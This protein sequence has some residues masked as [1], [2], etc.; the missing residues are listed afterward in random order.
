MVEIDAFGIAQETGKFTSRDFL[1]Q[2]YKV[3]AKFTKVT[4]VFA[5]RSNDVVLSGENSKQ[6]SILEQC[7]LDLDSGF[8]CQD[9]LMEFT[10]ESKLLLIDTEDR[11]FSL[12][13]DGRSGSIY[14]LGP[15]P[16]TS[17]S[18][19][20]YVSYFTFGHDFKELLKKNDISDFEFSRTGIVIRMSDKDT[21]EHTLD[22]VTY[23]I[24][25]GLEDINRGL[26]KFKTR[27]GL[28]VSIRDNDLFHFNETNAAHT[29]NMGAFLQFDLSSD[30]PQED[31]NLTLTA[32]DGEIDNSVPVE[33]KVYEALV[34]VKPQIP[35]MPDL[36]VHPNELLTIKFDNQLLE[37]NNL[38]F[39]I[40]S[41]MKNRPK[42]DSILDYTLNLVQPPD[43]DIKAYSFSKGYV[44]TW[45]SYQNDDDIEVNQVTAYI[46]SPIHQL[47]NQICAN[48][49]TVDIFKGEELLNLDLSYN[50]TR[51][52]FLVRKADGFSYKIKWLNTSKTSKNVTVIKFVDLPIMVKNCE[53]FVT[54]NTLYSNSLLLCRQAS[55]IRVFNL[56][57]NANAS[58]ASEF[59]PIT[60]KTLNLTNFC[61][62]SLKN[63]QLDPKLIEVLSDCRG[64]EAR[65]IQI[66][67]TDDDHYNSYF[68]LQ[69][70]FALSPKS[71]GEKGY[72][73]CPFKDEF[74]ILDLDSQ[75]I[76]SY[77]RQLSSVKEYRSDSIG[78][79][80]LLGADCNNEHSVMTI[81]GY[82]LQEGNHVDLV[83]MRANNRA[84]DHE[85]R[86]LIYTTQTIYEDMNCPPTVYSLGGALG[87]TY[88]FASDDT[89]VNRLIFSDSY[90]LM[91]NS[92]GQNSTT[93]PFVYKFTASNANSDKITKFGNIYIKKIDNHLNVTKK[94]DKK[95]MAKVGIYNLEELL[96]IKGPVLY[97]NLSEKINHIS[98]SPR[99][100]NSVYSLVPLNLV[101]TSRDIAIG[102]IT[103]VPYMI[104]YKHYNKIEKS[105]NLGNFSHGVSDVDIVYYDD[106]MTGIL[107]AGLSLVGRENCTVS[108]FGSYDGYSDGQ[109]FILKQDGSCYSEM[110]LKRFK[111]TNRIIG[112]FQSRVNSRM[113]IFEFTLEGGKMAIV[114]GQPV[115]IE[116]VS[117]FS[118]I[119]N[120]EETVFTVV[121][122][123]GVV[124]STARFELTDLQNPK[125]SVLSPKIKFIANNIKCAELSPQCVADATGN[126]L[127]HFWPLNATEDAKIEVRLINKFNNFL[128][129]IPPSSLAIN[130]EFVAYHSYKLKPTGIQAAVQL[131]DV[132]NTSKSEYNLTHQQL[133]NNYTQN[134][135]VTAAAAPF[136]FVSLT[137]FQF[138]NSLGGFSSIPRS[139]LGYHEGGSC[140]HS[141]RRQLYLN[142][143]KGFHRA[144]ENVKINVVGLED[145]SQL[146][147][148]VS[149]KVK[150]IIDLQTYSLQWYYWLAIVI[151]GALILGGVALLFYGKTES[152]PVMDEDGYEKSDASKFKGSLEEDIFGSLS[153]TEYTE[154][155]VKKDEDRL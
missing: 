106:K 95:V 41:K 141:L 97:S 123:F 20:R 103:G 115:I 27:A 138:F 75:L 96:D 102:S 64:L 76:T 11:V 28:M 44:A 57:I 139:V 125:F 108:F 25:H 89:F 39:F 50:D 13:L 78:F 154:S 16:P 1:R 54:V 51:P 111:G 109:E 80:Q 55:L 65:V 150:T 87:I 15:V 38:N 98:M 17:K 19:I 6:N 21:G 24:R 35:D 3:P 72:Q 152:D 91:V 26:N 127:Y 59:S 145:K 114:R 34:K 116:Q 100:Q 33:L 85:G 119:Q 22:Y 153:K 140:W 81:W 122:S 29:K 2:K 42:F 143:T 126:Q 133:I 66:S 93:E 130:S 155:T 18:F 88:N 134:S 71:E 148:V 37:G 52:L 120:T 23:A 129:P 147:R 84:R 77:D 131:F 107:A 121:Y 8:Q 135:S 101:K 56:T 132:T 43:G 69:S 128:T 136:G 118:V 67:I 4:D 68:D 63:S 113:E 12:S 86:R 58:K 92:F 53:D 70:S 105:I 49:T 14:S 46:C 31:M 83:F 48:V 74:L 117:H 94:L 144:N 110:T 36:F 40:Y 7:N 5:R 79:S 45:S 61:P 10:E 9:G 90:A 73:F 142:F 99:L 47:Q 82:T 30:F 137:D 104:V 32:T 146:Q 151:G 60:A 62:G 149:V 124:L 112:F